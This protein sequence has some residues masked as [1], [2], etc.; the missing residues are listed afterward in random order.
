[1]TLTTEPEQAHTSG[2]HTANFFLHKNDLL[3]G[4]QVRLT[5]SDLP[6]HMARVRCSGDAVREI[7]T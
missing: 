1:M 6:C 7:Y 4:A 5:C 2:L 3:Y